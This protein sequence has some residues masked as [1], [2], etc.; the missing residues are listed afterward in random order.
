MSQVS[1]AHAAMTQQTVNGVGPDRLAGL[2]FVAARSAGGKA[3]D[4]TADMPIGRGFIGSQQ[5]AQLGGQI[6]I[7]FIDP[8]QPDPSRRGIQ[9][10]RLVKQ[11]LQPLPARRVHR[12]FS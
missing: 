9:L 8:L 4:T 3:L 2:E 10:N 7:G 6:G 12:V 5:A 1:S 11:F